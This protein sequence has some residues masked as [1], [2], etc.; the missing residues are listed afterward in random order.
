MKYSL[1]IEPIFE[2]VPFLERFQIAKDLGC[3]AVEFWDPWASNPDVTPAKLGKASADAG[4]PIAACCLNKAWTYRM[5]FPWATVTENVE[6]SM[7]YAK[8]MGV[9]T[10]I[11]LSG[12]VMCKTDSEKI[13]LLE[14]DLPD[15]F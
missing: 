11:G 15:N 12:E 10:M 6:L 1:C 7:G 3:D 5:T 9:K 2:D 14:N 8:E 4:I 13:L